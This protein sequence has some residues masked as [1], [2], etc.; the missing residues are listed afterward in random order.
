MIRISSMTTFG[1]SIGR[2]R[3]V[4]PEGPVRINPEALKQHFMYTLNQERCIHEP[5]RQSAAARE[6]A[7][8]TPHGKTFNL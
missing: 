3:I 6:D 5:H 2:G 7:L 1:G 8:G 4:I